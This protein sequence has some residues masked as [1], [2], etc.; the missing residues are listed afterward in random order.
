MLLI[1]KFKSGTGFTLIEV[2]I[3]LSVIVTGVSAGLTL[4]TFN[5]NTVVASDMRLLAANFAR[6]GIEVIRHV[7]DS[8]WLA[9]NPWDK[10]ITDLGDY[11]LTVDFNNLT[12]AWSLSAQNFDITNCNNCKLYLDQLDG[13]YSHNSLKT[14][15]NFKREIILQQICWQDAIGDE[16]ILDSGI[17]CEAQGQELA[18]VE[19]HSLVNWTEN[20]ATQQLEAVDRLYNWR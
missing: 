6:E 1:T 16:A 4:T 7:R 17:T 3:A 19:I 5:L 15:T 13:V 18:G 20:G 12:N 8:N 11:R 14:L 2:I 10:G 9:N